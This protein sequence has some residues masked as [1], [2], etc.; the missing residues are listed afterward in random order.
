[1][2]VK[3]FA[4]DV[5]NSMIS[6]KILTFC[7]KYF[8]KLRIM[9]MVIVFTKMYTACHMYENGTKPGSNLN[10]ADK[11]VAASPRADILDIK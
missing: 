11:R 2:R 6:P 1:M 7:S 5:L 10:T 4:A 8:Q 9:F 3:P